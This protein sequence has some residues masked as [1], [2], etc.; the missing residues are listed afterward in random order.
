MSFNYV[1]DVAPSILKKMFEY[2]KRNHG[3]VKKSRADPTLIL[4]IL[5]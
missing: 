2:S 4:V 5:N 3:P 1:K